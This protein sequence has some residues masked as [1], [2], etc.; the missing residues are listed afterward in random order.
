MIP[1]VGDKQEFSDNELRLIG[2]CEQN[3]FPGY[4][5]TGRTPRKWYKWNKP[6]Y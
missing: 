4:E 1:P 3:D 6:V 5:Y 2:L